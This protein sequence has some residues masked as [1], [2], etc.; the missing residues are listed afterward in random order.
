[1]RLKTTSQKID[2]E[3]TPELFV[4]LLCRCRPMCTINFHS[5][6]KIS[7]LCVYVCLYVCVCACV[8]VCMCVCMCV[9]LRVCVC[10]CVCMCSCMCVCMCVYVHACVV[11]CASGFARG[12]PVDS[13]AGAVYEISCLS[14]CVLVC[15]RVSVFVCVCI[16]VYVW[17][18]VW[19][20]VLL[21]SPEDCLLTAPLAKFCVCVCVCV[22]VCVRICVCVHVCLLVCE[23]TGLSVDSAAGAVHRINSLIYT[24]P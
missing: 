13:A 9:Y 10:M 15:V 23:A 12:L 17:L 3:V 21:A 7:C 22:L 8:C 16:C 18:Y 14:V 24:G 4:G 6:L 19:L 11:V 1:M 20:Y 2:C 5:H